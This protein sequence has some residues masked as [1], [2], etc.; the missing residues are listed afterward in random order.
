MVVNDSLFKE[1]KLKNSLLHSTILIIR[2]VIFVIYCSAIIISYAC[3]KN[4][5]KMQK[6]KIL[7]E[8]YNAI[9]DHSLF[10][11]TYLLQ[12]LPIEKSGV[13][14]IISV[15]QLDIQACN[16]QQCVRSNLFEFA[17]TLDKYIPNFIHYQIVINEQLLYSDIKVDNYELEKNY[18][19]NS[20][21]QLSISIALDDQYWNKAK[22][23][24]FKPFVITATSS[25]LLL[26]L[27]ILHNKRAN[28]HSEKLYCS[29]YKD[30]YRDEVEKIKAEHK[31]EFV[32]KENKLMQKIWNLEYGKEKDIELNYLFSQEASKLAMMSQGV[33]DPNSCGIDSSKIA[34]CSIILYSSDKESEKIDTNDLV[35]VFSSRFVNS[36]DNISISI[37]SLE[38]SI[39]FLSKASLYQIIYS[40][41]S[42]II[43]LLKE[44]SRTSTYNIKFSIS[45]KKDN[46]YLLFEYDGLPLHKEEEVLK[47]STRFLKKA[48]N[49]FLLGVDQV[50]KILRADDFNCDIFHKGLNCLKITKTVYAKNLPKT[51]SNIIKLPIRNE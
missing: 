15:G 4:E 25:T 43:F 21:N 48:A 2:L 24:L 22:R 30:Y 32:L 27:F 28:K 41:M 16:K 40:V 34:P 46:L 19:I 26:L 9:F 33:K 45:D 12:K 5:T 44:Q 3:C 29:Y 20:D 50:L 37:N 38:K 31:K 23:Q 7:T 18:Y 42:Y 49:P 17:S 1:D 39:K 35:K 8:Y 11:L 14:T 51:K 13:D 10:K 47:F 6:N 36:E